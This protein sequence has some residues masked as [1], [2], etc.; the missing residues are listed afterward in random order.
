MEEKDKEQGRTLSN[1]GVLD[2]RSATQESVAGISRVGNVGVVLYSPESAV[3]VARL[4][5][6]NLGASLEAPADAQVLTGQVTFSRDYF[7]NQAKPLNLVVT[8]QLVVYPD[9]P[10]EEIEAGLGELVI[11]GQLICP[12]HL[13]GAIHSKISNLSGQEITYTKSNS[14]RIAM[15]KVVLDENYLMSLQ[16]GSELVVI[17][18]LTLPGVLPNELLEEKIRRIQVVGKVTCHEENAQ[19]ILARLDDK[20]GSTRLATIPAGFELVERPLLLDAN[21]LE[22]LP[23]RKL[24]CASRVQVDSGV[25]AEILDNALEALVADGLVICPMVLKDVISRKCNMLKTQVVLYEGELWLVEEEQTLLPS[26]FTHLQ[27]KATLMVLDELSI[28]PDV[29]PQVLKERLAKVH[30]LDTITCTPEQMGIIEAKMGLSKGELVDST[31]VKPTGEEGM[32]NVGYLK[33]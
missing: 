13:V 11:S 7:K 3:L 32:D 4:N 33:L 18:K 25:D 5:I 9:V 26:R 29:D 27:D 16:D 6:G 10:A 31:Q 28:A 23:A 12:E 30:N 17:G 19:I 21:L 1:I 22:A 14:T 24:Y 8:G 2:L 20:M 15:G